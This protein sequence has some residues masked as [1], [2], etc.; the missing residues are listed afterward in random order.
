MLGFESFS[1][2]PRRVIKTLS[3]F[4]LGNEPTAW[5]NLQQKWRNN[6]FMVINRTKWM[7]Q[8]A[9]GMDSCLSVYTGS[10]SDKLRVV[11]PVSDT[12]LHES[13]WR[14]EL[15]VHQKHTRSVL[16]QRDHHPMMMLKKH[17][18]LGFNADCI[19]FIYYFMQQESTPTCM[20]FMS[21]LNLNMFFY[22]A[23][24]NKRLHY[25]KHLHIS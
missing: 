22:K 17:L 24:I 11:F 15:K 9:A 4:Y 3:Q 2:K 8:R 1:G 12:E 25:T 5:I 16:C 6:N 13:A 19:Y 18:L 20:F 21:H 23:S 7:K 10:E 14:M